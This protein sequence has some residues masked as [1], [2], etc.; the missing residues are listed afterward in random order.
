MA[1]Y[2]WSGAAVIAASVVGGLALYVFAAESLWRYW[3]LR[4]DAGWDTTFTRKEDSETLA[5]MEQVWGVPKAQAWKQQ[6]RPQT[7]RQQLD[8]VIA[9][10]E[11]RAR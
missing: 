6:R 1:I 10:S 3:D 9:M 4:E 7:T 11:R 2:F 5:R 8:N